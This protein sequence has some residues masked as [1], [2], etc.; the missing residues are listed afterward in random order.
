MKCKQEHYQAIKETLDEFLSRVDIDTKITLYETGSFP[1]ADK[2]KDL[3]KRFCFDVLY[4]VSLPFEF[5]ELYKY[6]T[7]DHIYTVLKKLLPKVT[8]RY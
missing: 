3:Q 1:R 4:Q 8:R 2:V 5:N 6:M 7:D